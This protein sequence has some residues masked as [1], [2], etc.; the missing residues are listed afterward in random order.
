MLS[1]MKSEF[2]L[3]DS[4]LEVIRRNRGLFIFEGVLLIV[5][6][7][8]AV[9]IPQLFTLGI[10]LLIGLF[11]LVAGVVSGWRSFQ[12]KK[13]TGFIWSAFIAL[14]YLVVGVLLLTQ[15]VQGI[16]TLTFILTFF[17][18]LEG[19]AQVVLA[20]QFRPH[21]VWGWRLLSGLI[22]LLLAYL[23][24]MGWPG[25]AAW[26]MGLLV[27]INLLFAGFTQL[28]LALSVSKK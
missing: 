27:G 9:A 8:F 3:G 17:F 24:W 23:I 13:L 1:R 21:G 16:L 11:F 4:M 14:L 19:I 25:S 20:F 10:E 18:L 6:G 22:S 5:M 12:A 15:P 26:V 2:Y 28:F 7:L